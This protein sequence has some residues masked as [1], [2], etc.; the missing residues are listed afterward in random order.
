[1]VLSTVFHR[2]VA[3]DIER[4]TSAIETTLLPDMVVRVGAVGSLVQDTGRQISETLRQE[5]LSGRHAIGRVE[6]SV[7]SLSGRFDQGVISLQE[8]IAATS[9][10]S[11]SVLRADS[12]ENQAMVLRELAVTQ[13]GISDLSDTIKRVDMTLS[14]LASREELGR[15][16]AKP[17][18]LR[19]LCD[20]MQW[21]P[22]GAFQD[23]RRDP[24]ENL[25]RRKCICQKRLRKNSKTA[26][27]WGPWRAFAETST[28]HHHFPD[29]VYHFQ[30]ADSVST[31]WVVAFNG[32]HRVINRAVEL[33][34]SYSFGAG[35][36]S[37]SPGFTYYPSIDGKRDPA[38]RI[39][40][41]MDVFLKSDPPN[42]WLETDFLE[43]AIESIIL[44][45]RHGK[46]SPKALDQHGRSILH[47]YSSF[48]ASWQFFYATTMTL[49]ANLTR[50]NQVF[51]ARI[52]RGQMSPPGRSRYIDQI[53]SA[54]HRV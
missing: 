31:R 18:Q 24:C 37:L 6:D 25:A 8:S 2:D 49:L 33:S 47:S 35:G 48:L 34:F 30:S 36:C 12:A 4:T 20:S 3:I 40:S 38:F 52:W 50:K 9:T 41:L 13:S 1:M 32:L 51:S 22:K 45:Y 7:T 26:L 19:E 11:V 27:A 29:C 15:M 16:V 21:T 39:I 5:N 44:L 17:S 43:S 46:A 54:G 23:L 14:A 28:T 10:S 42:R 53:W